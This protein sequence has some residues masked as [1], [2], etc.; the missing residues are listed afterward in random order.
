VK[1]S[2]NRFTLNPSRPAAKPNMSVERLVTTVRITIQTR[3][4]T[5]L[6]IRNFPLDTGIVSIVF[7]VCSLYSLPNRYD[8]IIANIMTA[9]IADMYILTLVNNASKVCPS[10]NEVTA[11]NMSNGGRMAPTMLN[12][13]ILDLLSFKNSIFIKVNI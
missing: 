12:K 13:N 1:L 2:K 5:Y 8:M 7:R 9:N 3:N 11:I 6:P 10:S 4:M